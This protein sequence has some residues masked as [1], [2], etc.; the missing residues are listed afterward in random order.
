[1]DELS[2]HFQVKIKSKMR[3]KKIA[4]GLFPE[5]AHVLTKRPFLSLIKNTWTDPIC[6]PLDHAFYVTGLQC[7]PQSRRGKAAWSDSHRHKGG[8]RGPFRRT[9]ALFRRP[10]VKARSAQAVLGGIIAGTLTAAFPRNQVLAPFVFSEPAAL[11][12]A[13][14]IRC[15]CFHARHYT[16]PCLF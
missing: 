1:M 12:A 15:R 3:S 16:R 6:F 4:Q 7:H 14:W 11:R 5:L 13:R 9:V 10:S 8:S 2:A